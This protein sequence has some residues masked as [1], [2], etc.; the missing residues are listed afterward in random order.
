M[1]PHVYIRKCTYTHSLYKYISCIRC[2]LW[3]PKLHTDLTYC[4]WG[5]TVMWE[6]CSFAT[7]CCWQGQRLLPSLVEPTAL[8][9]QCP[10]PVTGI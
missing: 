6:I 8:S 10:A 3:C 2:T 4:F 5:K 9:Y 1:E 7:V